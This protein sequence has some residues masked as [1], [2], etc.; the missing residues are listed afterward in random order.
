MRPWLVALAGLVLLGVAPTAPA[1]GA[2]QVD[3]IH[4]DGVIS[5]VT[6][7]LVETALGRAQADRAG[8]LRSE[9]RRVGKECR[10]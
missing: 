2:T 1:A 8:A 5:P 6:L 7:R 4:L 3:T 10:R 9:E